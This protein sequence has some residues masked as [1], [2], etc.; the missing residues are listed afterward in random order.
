MI[1]TNKD[2]I[3]FKVISISL[4]I[5]FLNQD[6][7]WAQGGQPVWLE[8]KQS[9]A[10]LGD[11]PLKRGQSP[12]TA[13]K[14]LNGISIPKEIAVTKGVSTASGDGNLIIN[15]QDAHASL[16][17]QESIVKVLDN[18]V[19]NYDLSLVAIEGSSGYIDTSL[20]K[21]FP[22]KNIKK[23]ISSDLMAKGRM[24]AGEFFTI[25]NDKDIALYGIDDKE[26]YRANLEQFRALHELGEGLKGDI[27]SLK[28]TISGLKAKIYSKE[29]LEL[30]SSSSLINDSKI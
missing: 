8:H 13:V 30:E 28:Q 29:A 19:T 7:V 15:I 17:A 6:L 23:E 1:Y 27:E 20:L 5:A 22:D 10:N 12:I 21:T 26:L 2:K 11:S 3:W 18:L 16:S 4:V 24:S 14:E 25:T 9:P